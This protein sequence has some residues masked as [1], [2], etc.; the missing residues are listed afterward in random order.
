MG[1]LSI[2]HKQQNRLKKINVVYI[3]THTHTHI[4]SNNTYIR[5]YTH[6][7]VSI[8]N[9]FRI[10]S[11]KLFGLKFVSSQYIG[12]VLILVIVLVKCLDTPS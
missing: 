4:H 5:N 6:T 12:A 3:H 2:I 10:A 8:T 1:H 7:D 11:S 9:F